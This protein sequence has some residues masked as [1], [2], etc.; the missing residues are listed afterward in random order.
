M[1]E[2]SRDLGAKTSESNRRPVLPIEE[3]AFLTCM[4]VSSARS[5][6]R[7]GDI[8]TCKIGKRLLVLADEVDRL[9]AAGTRPRMGKS[10]AA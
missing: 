6:A 5:L 8:A 1:P 10:V 2:T 9:V 3:F 4:S 7:R